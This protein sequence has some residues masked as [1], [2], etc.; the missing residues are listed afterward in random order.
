[1]GDDRANAYF[2]GQKLI[3][4]ASSFGGCIG[5]LVRSGLN[6]SA[7]P[8][9]PAMLER[10]AQGNT[11]EP[12]IVEELRRRG[13]VIE[14]AGENGAGQLELELDIAGKVAI[15]VHPDG[16]INGSL[17]K[18]WVGPPLASRVLE[19]KALRPSFDRG[20]V[21]YK[22]QMSIEMAA[23]GL[24]GLWVYGEKDEAGELVRGDDGHIQL[25]II[26][27]DTPP[28][29]LVDIKRRALAIYKA[30]NNAEIP[31]CDV[32]QYPCG[33]WR[34]EDAA[35]YWS[36]DKKEVAKLELEAG[37]V[38][39]F[40]T[41]K[42]LAKDLAVRNDEV[43]KLIKGKLAKLKGDKYES[44]GEN[45]GRL[46]MIRVGGSKTLDKAAMKKDGID[47]AKY[48]KTGRAYWRIDV[49]RDGEE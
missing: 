18:G 37:L 17:M 6:M 47:L 34:D 29:S 44:G 27:Q 12:V 4:R 19:I 25:D 49:G 2:E 11:A 23:S 30:V 41:N 24:R 3:L 48:E 22:W 8:P 15:R 1:M 31:G 14:G 32:K 36:P 45:G 33:F 42:D 10:F 7:A 21:N 46:T 13:Y 26:E 38:E 9:P 20:F 16:V 39:E 35:C 40:I 28:F 43:A 5:A